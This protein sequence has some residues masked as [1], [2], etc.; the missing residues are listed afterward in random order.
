[1]D[2][3]EKINAL[4][5]YAPS[6]FVLLMVSAFLVDVFYTVTLTDKFSLVSAG[7]V[8]V[9]LGSGLAFWAN[10]S[11]AIMHREIENDDVNGGNFCVGPYCFMRHP[12][13]TSL[14]LMGIGIACI[15]NSLAILVATTVYYLITQFII[16]AEESLLT[17]K[18]NN[19]YSS[20]QKSV[21]RYF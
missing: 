2:T 19:R 14:L 5:T 10:A 9:A 15:I 8:F 6:I 12:A 11:H 18:Y 4:S 16:Q 17:A 3:R 1:M 7:F 13:Y 21:G 20:Y